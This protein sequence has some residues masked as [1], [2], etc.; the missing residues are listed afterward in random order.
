MNA[1]YLLGKG[2]WPD[3]LNSKGEHTEDYPA[4]ADWRLTL[5]DP[6]AGDFL[7]SKEDIDLVLKNLGYKL[8]KL[9]K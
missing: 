6:E 7:E 3:E 4:W 5:F 8:V 1:T 9:E 2:Y